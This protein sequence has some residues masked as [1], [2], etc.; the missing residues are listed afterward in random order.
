M[1]FKNISFLSKGQGEE[2]KREKVQETHRQVPKILLE[3]FE[4]HMP[5]PVFL[6]PKHSW[7]HQ[8]W[9]EVPQEH[10]RGE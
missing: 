7:P 4:Y 2:G 1:L 8:G 10:S 5:S 9:G 3:G 6:D